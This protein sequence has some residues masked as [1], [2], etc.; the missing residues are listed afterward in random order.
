MDLVE[1]CKARDEKKVVTLLN[2]YKV[3]DPEDFN[4]YT[5]TALRTCI[6]FGYVDIS[7]VLL[8]HNADPNYRMGEY[9]EW[10]CSKNNIDII[11]LLIEYGLHTKYLDDAFVRNICY[12]NLSYN[13]DTQKFLLDNGAN[14][15]GDNGYPLRRALDTGEYKNVQMYLIYGADIKPLIG[16]SKEF[17]DVALRPRRLKILPLIYERLIVH[18]NTSKTD[19]LDIR[20]VVY[21]ILQY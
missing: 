13:L 14:V 12:R 1:A 17:I 4:F 3:Y 21:H 8:D 11:K 9:V 15:D 19:L 20:K 10:A 18:Q 2:K 16:R 6:Y 5:N 7:R